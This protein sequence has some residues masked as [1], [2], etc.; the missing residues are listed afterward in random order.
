M[1]SGESFL[2]WARCFSRRVGF[3]CAKEA[4]FGT[5]AAEFPVCLIDS[6]RSE[7]EPCGTRQIA[8]LA[9]RCASG[10]SFMSDLDYAS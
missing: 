7:V 3:R 1:D 2:S 4:A 8:L 10:R 6:S 9:K 5:R